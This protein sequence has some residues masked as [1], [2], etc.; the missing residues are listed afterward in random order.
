MT[1]EYKPV[2]LVMVRV[3]ESETGLVLRIPLQKTTEVQILSL[4]LSKRA[5]ATFK[6]KHSGSMK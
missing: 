5:T 2:I 4:V 3:P 1:L 6:I